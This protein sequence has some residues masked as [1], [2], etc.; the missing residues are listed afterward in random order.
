MQARPW[1][2]PALAVAAAAAVF[3]AAAAAHLDRACVVM[4]TPYLPLCPDATEAPEQVQAELRARLQANPGDSTA[5]TRLLVSIGNLQ[6]EA[7]LRAAS[8]VAPNN[9][10]V[11]RWRAA[12]AADRGESVEAVRLLV[13]MLRNRGSVEAAKVLAQLAASKEGAALLRP[14]LADAQYWL[15]AVL[16]HMNAQKIP[17]SEILPL[18]AEAIEKGVVPPAVLQ[19]YMRSLKASGQWLDAYG[20]WLTRHKQV[21]PLLYNGGFDQPLEGDGFDWELAPAMRSRAGVIAEQRSVARRGLVLELEFTGRTFRRPVVRQFVFAPPG[22]YRLRGEYNASKLRSEGGLAWKVV[23][24][25]GPKELKTDAPALKDTGGTWR[26]FEV[27]FT[28]PEDCGPVAG[29]QLEP[30][31]AFEAATGIKGRVAFDAFSLA[32]AA[33]E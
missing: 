19:S 8:I 9:G 4:D 18:M 23:C 24:T 2:L 29:I 17:P 26:T 3:L 7:V 5:W 20:L 27:Q 13:Q 6:A 11:L 30:A 21:V 10:N 28:V 33:Q 16:M 32:R 25:A 12:K 14:H 31:A 15:P 1:L 22:S